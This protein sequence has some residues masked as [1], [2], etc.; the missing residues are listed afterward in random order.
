MAWGWAY[1]PHQVRRSNGSVHD[2]TGAYLG[3]QV[4]PD[5]A[6]LVDEVIGWYDAVFEPVGTHPGYRRQGLG[7]A[8][9]RH[10][11]H[12]AREAGAAHMTVAC[13]GAPGRPQ[14]RGLYYGV[15][16]R[17]FTRD[18][19]LIKPAVKFGRQYLSGY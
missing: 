17:P 7:T 14:A 6:E 15:G 3:Y 9:L 18:A 8:M 16:F 5:Q 1:L 11:M 4:H 19:P 12:L 2:I 10:G 13:F